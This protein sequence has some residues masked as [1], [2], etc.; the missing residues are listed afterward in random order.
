MTGSLKMLEHRV[1]DLGTK[2]VAGILGNPARILIL[3]R[4]H[5]K[6]DG[7]L[8]TLDNSGGRSRVSTHCPS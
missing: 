4:Q 7:S 1:C 2:Q 6:S 5:A 3:A 8:R